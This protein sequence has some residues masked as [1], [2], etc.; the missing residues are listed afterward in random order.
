[1]KGLK[2]THKR[3]EGKKTIEVSVFSYLLI[4]NPILNQPISG[5]RFSSK[6]IPEA[7][8]SI[9]EWFKKIF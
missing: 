6:Y 3:I 2:I 8:I 1:M 4:T 9:N 5:S 7:K